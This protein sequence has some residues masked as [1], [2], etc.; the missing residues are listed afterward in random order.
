MNI[1]M[2]RRSTGTDMCMMNTISM[3]ITLNGIRR[4]RIVMCMCIAR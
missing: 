3:S 2:R 1:C 4:S